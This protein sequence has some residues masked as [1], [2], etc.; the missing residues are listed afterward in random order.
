[1]SLQECNPNFTVMEVVKRSSIDLNIAHYR[2][3]QKERT[4]DQQRP[5]RTIKVCENNEWKK[6]RLLE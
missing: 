4:F 5:K 3:K 6:C 2:I 1:M